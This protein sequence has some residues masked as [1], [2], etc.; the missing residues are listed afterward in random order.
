MMSPEDEQLAYLIRSPAWEG[1]YKARTLEQVRHIYEDLLDPSRARQ[2][3]RS[4]DFL[5]GQITAL[6]WALSWPEQEVE[7][8]REKEREEANLMEEEPL[9]GGPPTG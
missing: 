4:D 3:K 2:D 1:L 8:A 6:K 5:R 7:I 9:F